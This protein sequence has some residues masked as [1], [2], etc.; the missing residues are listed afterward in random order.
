MYRFATDPNNK[1]DFV[2]VY[3]FSRF[4]RNVTDYCNYRRKFREAGVRLISAT[5][6]I[7]DDRNGQL[8]ETILAAFDDH[9]SEVNSAAV[10]DMMAA[11]AEAGY[12]NGA[13]VPFGYKTI[14]A[15]ILNKKEKK[16]L[17]VE[18][19]EAAIVL[20]IYEWY[21]KGDGTV[22]PMGIKALTTRLN[23]LG[24]TLR[25]GQPFYT[26]A[27]E[28][29][30]TSETYIGTA[31][32]NR[33]DSRTG[34]QRPRSDWIKIPTPSIVT[35]SQYDAVQRLMMSRAPTVTA[36]RIVNGPT[37]LSGLATCAC[38]VGANGQRSGM[39][40]RTG[41]SGQYRY[42]VCA[43]RATKSV[44]RCD[45]PTLRMEMIDELVLSE[46]ERRVF[47]PDRLRNLL[48]AMVDASDE[49]RQQ[50][51]REIERQTAA[52]KKAEQ[53]VRNLNAAIANSPDL[54]DVDDPLFKEQ[55]ASAKLQLSELQAT[56]DNLKKRRLIGAS[57]ISDEKLQQFSNAVR[58]KLR[59]ADPAFRRQWVHL[60]VD[61]VVVAP[62]QIA[63][64]GS[65]DVL[66]SAL[67]QG[68]EFSTP[69]VPIF[70]RKW[71]ARKDSN[72]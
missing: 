33:R 4:F 19:K 64:R 38:C 44:V 13:R 59:D 15:C 65:K 66:F 35:Q 14:T 46:L 9:A 56:L 5:Q 8:M 12:W 26:S 69:M 3:N 20:L 42:L 31:Y 72:L 51:D 18:D 23:A 49:G 58:K 21:L 43:N 32:Y 30:L 45:A 25:D 54:F 53:A 24:Y 41:K 67:R 63:V 71:R 28:L 2:I 70:A 40:L 55:Y 27:V 68:N 16:Q 52:R 48:A 36:P 6:E 60:F 29:I 1:I 10:K 22:G 34:K 50:L 62:D 7:P 47:H 17:A 37:L 39:M 11:N 61:E 57:D